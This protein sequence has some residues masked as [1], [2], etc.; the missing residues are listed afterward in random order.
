MRIIGIL[1]SVVVIAAGVAFSVL[2]AQKVSINYLLGKADL[3]LALLLLLALVVGMG[4]AFLVFGFNVVKL[5]SQ[6][7]FLRSKLKSLE[8]TV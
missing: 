6:N 2:N 5:K 4:I 1:T 3:P 8:K 7:H